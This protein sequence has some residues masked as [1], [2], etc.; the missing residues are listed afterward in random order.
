MRKYRF[1]S[2]N[3]MIGN[4]MIGNEMIISLGMMSDWIKNI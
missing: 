4:E 1:R 3:E 2:Y